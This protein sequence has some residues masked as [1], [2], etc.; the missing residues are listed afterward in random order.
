MNRYEGIPEMLELFM[1]ECGMPE[2]WVTVHE[3]RDRFRLTRYQ[4]T[5]VSGFLRRLEFGRFGRFPYIVTRIER[6]YPFAGSRVCR[7]LVV[8]QGIVSREDVQINEP[9]IV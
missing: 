6:P 5:T 2:R 7:Y 1:E 4:C 9:G 3:L 8:R